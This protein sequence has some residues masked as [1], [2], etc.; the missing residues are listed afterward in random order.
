MSDDKRI[1]PHEAHAKIREGYAY[2]DV[3]TEEEFADGHPEGAL[4]VPILLAGA[5]GM[6]PNPDFATVMAASFAHDAKVIVG[7]K[8]GGRSHKAREALLGLGF[9]DV[10]DQRAGWDGARDAFGQ[11]TEPGWSRAGLPI[12]KGVPEGRSYAALKSKRP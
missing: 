6:T 12:E 7:C 3:R 8:A 2:V 4:N 9:V 11:V 1:S 5:G 10:L